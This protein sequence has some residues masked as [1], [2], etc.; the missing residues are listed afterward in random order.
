MAYYATEQYGEAILSFR[1]VTSRNANMYEA[2][3]NLGNAYL[4][5]REYN[6]A[7]AAYQRATEIRPDDYSA[8]GYLGSTYYAAKMY[9]KAVTASNKAF[10]MK[11]DEPW[12][13]CTLALS[14]FFAGD[15]AGAGPIFEAL[16]AADTTGQE[17]G[18]ATA[19]IQQA[20]VKNPSLKGGKEL[21][22]KLGAK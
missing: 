16:L 5:W 10:Q 19:D 4:I 22:Q 21:L 6:D 2:W 9:D 1:K 3:Y 20:L 11:S 14:K 8:W 18:K 12:I 13:M 7:V 17:V 15:A